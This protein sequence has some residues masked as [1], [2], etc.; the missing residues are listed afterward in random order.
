MCLVQGESTQTHKHT[1]SYQ[2]ALSGAWKVR[3]KKKQA[4]KIYLGLKTSGEFATWQLG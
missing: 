3:K 4:N 1:Q 2:N